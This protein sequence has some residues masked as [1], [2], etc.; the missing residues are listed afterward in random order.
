MF[1]CTH[2]LCSAL[3][4][5][6]LSEI[7]HVTFFTGRV[8]KM[9]RQGYPLFTSPDES[10]CSHRVRHPYDRYS[11]C[12]ATQSELTNYAVCPIILGRCLQLTLSVM[13]LSM[14][15]IWRT[16]RIRTSPAPHCSLGTDKHLNC[17]NK[18]ALGVRTQAM[19]APQ[20][21]SPDLAPYLHGPLSVSLSATS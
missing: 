7:Q 16:K 2:H 14:W 10:L 20:C 9:L 18:I 15:H 21:K 6:G 19:A 3:L 1:R 17:S 5:C 8:L 13:N 12:L 4:V 11:A